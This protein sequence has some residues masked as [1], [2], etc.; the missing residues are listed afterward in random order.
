MLLKTNMY[1]R[2]NP[3][4]S[5]RF[6]VA[7]E[8]CLFSTT[9]VSSSCG[10]LVA[11]RGTVWNSEAS[12]QLHFCLHLHWVDPCA[13]T[14]CGCY[15]YV[16]RPAATD[17]EQ[18][19]DR[20]SCANARQFTCIAWRDDNSLRQGLGRFSQRHHNLYADSVLLRSCRSSGSLLG[21]TL[22]EK[23]R[24]RLSLCC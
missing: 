16:F 9:C 18:L 2:G 19:A 6:S 13:E 21:M 23:C 11:P 14:I 24:N 1:Q 8:F 15:T 20:R 4:L 12:L 22:L 17:A 7:N 10:H 3:L 5:R